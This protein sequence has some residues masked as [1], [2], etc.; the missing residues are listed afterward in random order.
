MTCIIIA[1]DFLSLHSQINAGFV[2]SGLIYN[3]RVPYRVPTRNYFRKAPDSH[4]E[5][6]VIFTYSYTLCVLQVK[7]REPYCFLCVT[8]R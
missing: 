7:H 8:C 4:Y 2:H 3:Y 5:R 6:F 1:D